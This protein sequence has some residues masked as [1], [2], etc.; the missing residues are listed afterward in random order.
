MK[1][2]IIIIR[3]EERGRNEITRGGR[4]RL[5][6]D[7]IDKIE[8][9]LEQVNVDEKNIEEQDKGKENESEKGIKGE[10]ITL[11]SHVNTDKNKIT[12]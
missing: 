2:I 8:V 3:R 4:T 11:E 10:K 7:D 6:M 1:K 9:N 12:R 5:K